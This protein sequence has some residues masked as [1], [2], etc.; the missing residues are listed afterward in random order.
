[1][2]KYCLKNEKLGYESINI[3]LC[4]GTGAP[5]MVFCGTTAAW[6][7]GNGGRIFKSITPDCI[8]IVFWT[9]V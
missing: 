2:F 8:C 1:M 9:Y 3:R 7:L 5:P 4:S 6:L